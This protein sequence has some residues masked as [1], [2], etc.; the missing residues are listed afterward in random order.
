MSS[1][2]IFDIKVSGEAVKLSR[3]YG[4]LPYMAER[5]LMIFGREEAELFMESVSKG[6]PRSI[7][8]NTLAIKDCRELEKRLE[9]RGFVLRPSKIVPYGY[10]VEHSPVQLG[11]TIEHLLGY[12]F[13]QGIGS[14]AS[15][16]ALSPKPGERVADLAAAPGG[17]TTHIAQLMENRGTVLSVE[18]DAR[19]LAKLVSNIERMHVRNAVI[20]MGDILKAKIPEGAFDRIM[21]DAPCTGEGLIVYKRER[22]V[23]RTE[24]DLRKMSNYQQRLVE[25][26]F[27]FLKPGGIMAYV[28]CSI[29]PEENEYVLSSVLERTEDMEVLETR[30]QGSSNTPGLE[31]FNGVQFGKEMRKCLRLYPH[32]DGTEGFFICLMRRKN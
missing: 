18:I 14:M 26:S 31:E 28:T 27:R 19:R 17:K 29:A 32:R 4:I 21:L 20:L 23:T 6:I 16:I 7:R 15:V 3:R 5:Y 8:C 25:R 12:Y 24:E 2:K 11:A 22:M 9:E 30:L 10:Y 13:I 1:E